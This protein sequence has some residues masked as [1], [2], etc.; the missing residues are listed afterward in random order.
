MTPTRERVLKFIKEFK[1]DKGYPPTVREIAAGLGKKSAANIQRHL[2]NLRDDGK[3][4]WTP[5]NPRTIRIIGE[6][7]K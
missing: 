1:A 4:E 3:I 5:Y 6:V 2:E 7:R